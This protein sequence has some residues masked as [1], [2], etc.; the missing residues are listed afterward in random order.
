M[1]F[2]FVTHVGWC[3]SSQFVRFGKFTVA[4]VLRKMN[5]NSILV[6]VLLKACGPSGGLGLFAQS[7]PKFAHC[8]A[9]AVLV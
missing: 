4:R 6:H 7:P 3:G 8:G 2:E 9:T 1:M 5:L